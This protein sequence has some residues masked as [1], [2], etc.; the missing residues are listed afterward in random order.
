MKIVHDFSGECVDGINTYLNLEEFADDSND[1]VL[2]YGIDSTINESLK[3]QYKDYNRR[4]LLDLWSPC[5]LYVHDALGQ[6]YFE[7]CSYF[8]DVYS[9]CP[10]TVEWANMTTNS[11][12]WKY[13]FYP[14]QPSIA[15]TDFDKKYDVCFVGGIHS[16]DHVDAILAIEKFNYRFISQMAYKEATDFNVSTKQKLNL[17][18][19][20]KITI[21]YNLLYLKSDHVHHAIHYYPNISENL[22]FNSLTRIEGPYFEPRYTIPQ[23]KSRLHEAASGKSLILCKNEP[24]NLA[25]SYYRLDQDYLSFNHNSELSDIIDNLLKDWNSE[26]I[27]NII[28]SAYVQAHKYTT[29]NLIKYIEETL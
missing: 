15:P 25:D 6:N 14:W 10:F 12:K 23:F 9:I 22:A 13:V 1:K 27:Q 26:R 16:H 7:Q 11:N 3:E 21:C 24:W 20:S 19:Q 4:I 28:N 8:T 2:F 17:I 5:Q 29:K 18:A